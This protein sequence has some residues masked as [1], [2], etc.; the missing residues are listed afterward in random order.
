M[1]SVHAHRLQT[2]VFSSR[3]RRKTSAAFTVLPSFLRSVAASCDTD[4]SCASSSVLRV[5]MPSSSPCSRLTSSSF[6]ALASPCHGAVPNPLKPARLGAAV[7]CTGGGAFVF[8]RYSS[9][10]A[11]AHLLVLAG[12]QAQ[13]VLLTS[14]PVTSVFRQMRGSAGLLELVR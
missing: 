10:G 2:L 4:A 11:L 5:R 6:A 8:D 12:Q 9:L 1:H 7:P 14:G 3:R 13:L